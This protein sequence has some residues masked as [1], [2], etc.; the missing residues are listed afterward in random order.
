MGTGNPWNCAHGAPKAV[1]LR[2]LE[3]TTALPD[4]SPEQP[5]VERELSKEE[6]P[7]GDCA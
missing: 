5:Q 3:S 1:G 6:A 4:Q 2:P 7:D